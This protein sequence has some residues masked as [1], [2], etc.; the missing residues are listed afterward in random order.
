MLKNMDFSINDNDWEILDKLITNSKL[1]DVNDEVIIE[2][3]MNFNKMLKNKKKNGSI[4]NSHCVNCNSLDLVINEKNGYSVCQ[5]CGVINKEIVDKNYDKTNSNKKDVSGMMSGTNNGILISNGNYRLK[6]SQMWNYA[7]YKETMLKSVLSQIDS[8]CN[9]NGIPKSI[10]DNAK[11]LYKNISETKYLDGKNKGKNIIFRA[12]NR[13]SVI[14]ACIFIGSKLSGNP[15]TLKEIA[16]IFKLDPTVI[17]NGC[18]NFFKYIRNS[19]VTYMINP[20]QPIDFIKRYYDEIKNIDEDDNE[21]ELQ[22]TLYKLHNETNIKLSKLNENDF[23]NIKKILDNINSLDLASDHQSISIASSTLYLYSILNK[24]NI[25]KKK[26]SQIF[27]ISEVTITKTF[28]KIYPF[29]NIILNDELTNML[30]QKIINDEDIMDMKIYICND[31]ISKNKEKGRP[32][33]III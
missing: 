14:A 11:I 18:K 27:K 15:R 23:N 4:F 26:L 6:M 12:I 21:K 8:Y 5:E 7:S 10:S 25:S 33:K 17:T 32:K 16:E 20:T 1:E 2:D 9:S 3:F 30:L 28:R 24:K 22:E 13:K 31:E 19:N 29:K